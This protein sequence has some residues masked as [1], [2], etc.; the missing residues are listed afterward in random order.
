MPTPKDIEASVQAGNLTQAERQLREVLAE[1]PTS[2]RAHYELGQVL[3]RE[4][5]YDEA[6]AAL[7]Q[8]KLLDSSLKFATSA[9]QFDKV[10]A[11]V[12][13]K[14]K[15]ARAHNASQPATASAPPPVLQTPS[16]PVHAAGPAQAPS[17]AQGAGGFSWLWGLL[18]V[19]G[20][21][22]LMAR[23]RRGNTQGA[24]ASPTW[25]AGRQEP[26]YS[27]MSPPPAQPY[28]AG[29]P[30]AQSG[31]A[32][33]A[34]GAV[35]GGLAGLAAGYA[36]SR[37]LDDHHDHG[38][39]TDRNGDPRTGPASGASAGSGDYIPFDSA[40]PTDAGFGAFDPGPGESWGG[41]S[42]GD[43]GDASGNDW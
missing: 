35:L 41:S 3:A 32:G 1:K 33:M 13:D 16:S 21:V 8:A 2:A 6:L 29:Y 34:R 10:M 12:A 18:A 27:P 38:A 37:T 5:R 31:A 24:G 23:L 30:A 17:A 4:G 25:G 14:A 26:V 36:L 28:G 43:M 11:A 39:N 20:V 42:A 40:S 22:W 9:Q 7:R 15:A 19:V